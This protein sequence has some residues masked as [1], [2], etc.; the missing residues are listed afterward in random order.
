MSKVFK[1]L[2]NEPELR[3]WVIIEGP[4]RVGKGTLIKKLSETELFKDWFPG[5]AI[6][7]TEL[8]E[9]LRAFL[10]RN[11]EHISADFR[12]SI[13]DTARAEM[14]TVANDSK[15][16]GLLSDRGFFSTLVYQY[17]SKKVNHALANMMTTSDYD[18]CFEEFYWP[19]HQ[20]KNRW[21]NFAKPLTIV[22]WEDEA[23]M[24]QRC[25]AERVNAMDDPEYQRTI[26]ERYLHFGD[27][28]T[29][30]FPTH[31]LHLKSSDPNLVEGIVEATKQYLKYME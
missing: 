26:R 31:F 12:C 17:G 16:P 30:T 4:D 25:Q 11:N 10:L 20:A 8:S 24:E 15:C 9:H 27:R 6:G 23:I 22:L 28:A 1:N 29:A 3:P 7:H 18:L 21:H 5:V 13:L 2:G 14:L 19:A